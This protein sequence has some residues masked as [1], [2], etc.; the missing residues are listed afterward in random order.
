[1]LLI[2]KAVGKIFPSYQILAQLHRQF[3]LNTDHKNYLEPCAPHM[4]LSANGMEAAMPIYESKGFKSIKE[5]QIDET[6]NAVV[7]SQ[8][9]VI[10]GLIRYQDGI[11]K[12]L[13]VPALLTA[14]RV[15]LD[16]EVV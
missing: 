4:I 15:S 6:N 13:N 1:M 9:D 16:E 3:C 11:I 2:Q 14:A 8:R 5:F 12:L 10:K 7:Y